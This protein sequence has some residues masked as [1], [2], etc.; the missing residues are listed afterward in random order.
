MRPL[1]V[2]LLASAALAGAAAQASAETCHSNSGQ[3]ADTR[4]CVSSVL[5][6]K[7]SN[8]YGP[9]HLGT[10]EATAAWCEGADGPGIG[11]TITLHQ[12]PA[13]M[14]G[15]MSFVNGYAKSPQAF[16]SNGRVK[17][18]RIETSGGYSKTVA[19]QDNT[20]WQTIKISPSKVS[21]IRLTILEVYPGSRGSDTCITTFYLNQEDF[22]EDE[23]K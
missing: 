21:W 20:E 17:R 16:S 18:A 15:S 6:P 1:L 8:R 14:I 2:V 11:Q 4:T 12:K 13:N 22:L 23:P 3:Y 19:L 5:P 9:D 7:G 10:G